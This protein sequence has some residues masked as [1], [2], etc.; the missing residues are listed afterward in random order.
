MAAGWWL[1]LVG[2]FI[3]SGAKAEQA[4]AADHHLVDLAAVDVMTPVAV[5]A[6][7][8]WTIEQLVEH[9]SPTRMAV[10]VFPVV[11][12][13][14]H[15]V[16]VCTMADLDAVPA[17]H[18]AD[19]KVSAL[20]GRHATPVVVPPDASAAEVAV[21]IRAQGGVA[22]VEEAGHP[23]GVVRALELDRAAHLSVLGWRTAPHPA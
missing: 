20:A 15:T 9:L 18:R 16:G 13:A 3:L 7:G 22:V 1:A 6:P 2:W 23:I 21:Q 14:G 5:V 19:T 4:A 8:W 17:P 10:G 11:D 12:F